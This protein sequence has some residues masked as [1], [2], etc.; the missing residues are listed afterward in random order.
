MYM[1]FIPAKAQLMLSIRLRFTAAE[2]DAEL[3]A[4]TAACAEGRDGAPAGGVGTIQEE[5]SRAALER[6]VNGGLEAAVRDRGLRPVG[7]VLS[8]EAHPEPGSPLEVLLHVETLPALRYPDSFDTFSVRIE[9]AIPAPRDLAAMLQRMLRSRARLEDV[10][11]P[12]LPQPGDVL[13]V[14]IEASCDGQAVPGMSARSYLINDA[15]RERTPEITATSITL[16]VGETGRYTTPCPAD[17]PDASLRGRSLDVAVTLTRLMKEN[18]PAI[19]DAFASSLGYRDLAHLRSAIFQDRMAAL[20]DRNRR[21]AEQA[22]L[23]ELM[24]DASFPVPASLLAA[25]RREQ[26]L[27]A[28]SAYRRRHGDAEPAGAELERLQD[29]ATRRAQWQA[30]AQTWL[31]GLARE[32]GIALGQKEVDRRVAAMAEGLRRPADELRRELAESGAIYELEDR[33][34]AEKALSWAYGQTRKVIVDRQ[35]R[36]VDMKAEAKA[37]R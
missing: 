2:V 22:L 24:G 14:D 10:A 23:D 8:D 21:R 15:N 17:Y 37:N 25:H 34:L 9:E 12:R 6:L 35:G 33:M 18:L 3:A 26:E 36:V 30:R 13:C 11:E 20:V 27:E 32:K 7:R 4:A 1:E 31:L 28:R 19:D 29:E 16:R 5:V